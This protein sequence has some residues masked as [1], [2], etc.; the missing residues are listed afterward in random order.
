MLEGLW[1]P[2]GL[3]KP[4]APL[5]RAGGGGWGRGHLGYLSWPAA[6]TV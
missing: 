1:I 3:G 2:P 4:R 5:G 6:T